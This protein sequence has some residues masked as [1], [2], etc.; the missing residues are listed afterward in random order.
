MISVDSSDGGG[1]RAALDHCGAT[2]MHADPEVWRLLVDAGWSGGPGFAALCSGGAVAPQLGTELAA[3][4]GRA[5]SLQGMAETAF[6]SGLTRLGEDPVPGNVGRPLGDGY[7][8]IVDGSLEALPS[9]V[10]G[11]LLV[12]GTAVARGYLGSPDPARHRFLPDPSADDPLVRLVRTG[13]RVRVRDGGLVELLDV[14]AG[15]LAVHGRRVEAAE[16]ELA[17]V[18][19][20][21]VLEAAVSVPGAPDDPRLVAHVTHRPGAGCTGSELRRHLRALLPAHMVPRTFV[22]VGALPR[23]RDGAIDRSRL[24]AVR[25][26][27][28]AVVE[29]RTEAEC[30]LA[31]LWREALGVPHVGLYDNFF[32][33]G[34]HSLLCLQVITQLERRTGRRLDPRLLL[35]NTLE[36]A[37]ARLAVVGAQPTAL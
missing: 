6:W 8:H 25:S 17:L 29:P 13:L 18:G 20:P 35:L 23:D 21:D 27:A 28:A 31:G 19:H 36:Q 26:A 5:F 16:V 9:G 15:R 2:A 3:R 34:G 33:L 14:E 7:W 12:G 24:P 10:P 11:E 1:L 32:D 22:E 4:A 30:L 37:A